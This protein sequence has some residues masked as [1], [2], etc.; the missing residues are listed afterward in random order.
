[1]TW[2]YHK[3]SGLAR[4]LPGGPYL[5]RVFTDPTS[6]GGPATVTVSWGDIEDRPGVFPPEEHQHAWT[7]ITDKPAT[8][9]PDEHTHAAADIDGLPAEPLRDPGGAILFDINGDLLYP[10][11]SV[12]VPPEHAVF[13]SVDDML[14]AD[15]ALWETA[16]TLGWGASD[17]VLLKWE[18][19]P[20]PYKLVDSGD[21]ILATIDGRGFAVR[22]GGVKV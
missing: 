8:F 14:F 10:P 1:M 21:A 15:S 5:P 18:F 7:D 4:P 9:P 6:P 22:M 3:R 11:G 17:G 19:V 12:I 16:T 13:D 20:G 2:W